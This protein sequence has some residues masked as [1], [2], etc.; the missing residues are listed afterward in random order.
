MREGVFDHV[1]VL[2]AVD[3]AQLEARV[4]LERAHH[5]GSLEAFGPG[6]GHHCDA[7]RVETHAEAHKRIGCKSEIYGDRPMRPP[8]SRAEVVSAAPVEVG[9]TRG[10]SPNATTL[11]WTR[12]EVNACGPGALQTCFAWVLPRP[13]PRWGPRLAATRRRHHQAGFGRWRS[14]C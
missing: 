5:G 6:T 9:M 7:G 10:G 8:D 13:E 2:A 4:G 3:Q 12:P 14:P 11:G 1:A